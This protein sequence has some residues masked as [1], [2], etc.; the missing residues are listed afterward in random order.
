MKSSIKKELIDYSDQVRS[1]IDIKTFKL[2]QELILSEKIDEEFR[3]QIFGLNQRLI[4]KSKI[5]FDANIKDVNL[6]FDFEKNPMVDDDEETI[7]ENALTSFCLF[8]D[9]LKNKG[10]RSK[11]FLLGLLIVSDWYLNKNQME[12]LR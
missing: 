5:V 1:E 12:Y 4:D 7:K 3:Q 8:I 11:N 2:E 6:Y 10:E 9:D